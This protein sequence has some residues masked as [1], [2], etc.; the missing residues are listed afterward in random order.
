VIEKV[1]ELESIEANEDDLNAEFEKYA[2]MQ[3][4]DV[5]SVKKMFEADNFEYIKN[6]IAIRKTVDFLVDNAKLK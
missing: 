3:K 5:E 2:E 6:T 4:Q 1:K